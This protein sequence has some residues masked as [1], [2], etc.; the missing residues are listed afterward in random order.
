[1]QDSSALKPEHGQGVETESI[2]KV[3]SIDSSGTDGSW[4]SI[5]T[6]YVKVSA[7]SLR[8]SLA[9]LLKKMVRPDSIKDVVNEFNGDTTQHY[10]FGASYFDVRAGRV[11]GF[12]ISDSKFFFGDHICGVGDDALI[13]KRLFPTSYENWY[14]IERG[15]IVKVTINK[16]DEYL[17][18]TIHAGKIIA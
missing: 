12:F 15:E 11:D 1:V 3:I 16:S 4:N 5:P 2:L 10:Y 6:E 8:D 18:F 14:A 7:I 9:V 17:L 13:L